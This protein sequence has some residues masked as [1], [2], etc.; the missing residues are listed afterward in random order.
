MLTPHL[1]TDTVQRAL[2]EDAPWGISP[3]N[4]QSPPRPRCAL[5]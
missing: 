5:Y 1:V 2:A 4:S 3:A